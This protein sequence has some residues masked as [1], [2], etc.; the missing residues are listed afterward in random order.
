MARRRKT[1]PFEDLISLAA[2]LPWWASLLIALVSWFLLHGFATSAP[3]AMTHPSQ[4]S[5]A[6]TGTVLRSL[7]L[8]GQYVVPFIFVCGAIGSI[9]GRA[10]RKKLIDD[11]ATAT[12]PGKTVDGISWREFEQLVGEA[13]RRKGFT[14]VEKGGSGPDGGIDLVLHL[15]TDKYLVQCKQWKA[16]KVGVTVIREFF[17]VMAAEG[18]AGGFVVTSGTYTEEAK[19]FAQGRNIQLVDGNL[20]KRW[21][22]NRSGPE[23]PA[24]ATPQPERP[25]AQPAVPSCPVC[26]ASMVIRTAKRGLNLGNQFW[27]CTK[28][29]ACKGVRQLEEAPV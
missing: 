16:I 3:P 28:F 13:F 26:N 17:G 4:F 27:G 29:P 15:G 24:K 7:A 1:S 18:A 10:K 9:A 19:A 5:T 25:L 2:L 12:Q 6:M 21:I 23:Q 22:A 11:V 14:V 8:V 20:L